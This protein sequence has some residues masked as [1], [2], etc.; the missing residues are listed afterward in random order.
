MIGAAY[1]RWTIL[2]TFCEAD[3]AEGPPP[4]NVGLSRCDFLHSSG[5]LGGLIKMCI[6]FGIMTCRAFKSNQIKSLLLSHHHNTSALVSE[7]LT[8]VLQTVQ[9]K[10]K[11]TY[12]EIC[13]VL[14]KL[15]LKSF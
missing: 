7:I 5:F 14:L 10:I 9:K 3:I 2:V 15:K 4:G 1:W 8:S 12:T 11:I 6:M 13:T